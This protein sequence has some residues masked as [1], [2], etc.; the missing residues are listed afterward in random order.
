MVDQYCFFH[1]IFNLQLV[2]SVGIRIGQRPGLYVLMGIAMGPASRA[3][4]NQAESQGSG[5]QV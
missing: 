1:S 3:F 4:H 2:Y 5:E